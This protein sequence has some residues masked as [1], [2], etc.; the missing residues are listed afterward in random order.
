MWDLAI[1]AEIF[2]YNRLPHSTNN[3]KLPMLK[4]NPKCYLKLEQI[5]RFSCIAYIKVQGKTGPTFSQL[6][7]KVILVG[8]TPPG[9]IF[10]K[11]E[12]GKSQC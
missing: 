9:Y 11:P 6:G 12:E 8:Y 2:A 3:I 4:F 5:K 1:D 10:F 7:K